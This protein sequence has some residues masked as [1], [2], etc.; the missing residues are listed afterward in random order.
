MDYVRLARPDHWFKN[1]FMVPGMVF[2]YMYFS[3]E[4]TLNLAQNVVIG[5]IATCLIA[6]ANYVINEWLD[7]EFDRH[8]PVKKFRPSV[9][10]NLK[11]N[12]I[13]IEYVGLA[14]VGLGLGYTISNAFFLVLL[15]LLIMGFLY[16]V[17]PFRTKDRAYIDV[18]SESVNNPIRF[19]LGWLIFAPMVMP[20]SSILVAYWMGGAFLMAS[21]RFAE[22]RFI[23][24]KS[25][26]SLYRKSFG[27][28][29]ETS[30]LVSAFYYAVACTFFLG[31]F[32]IKHRIELLLTFPFLALMFSWYLRIAHRQDSTAQR[33][34]QLYHN[35][36]FMIFIGLL[37]ALF[38]GLLFVDIPRLDYFLQNN[39]M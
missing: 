1:V 10:K 3:P 31:I 21:K 12:I 7:A 4:I 19:V 30:L 17:K 20:P 16:N 6:S 23:N 22:Y 34:E 29:S 38:L 13:Y 24:D 37:T 18:L 14:I 28:Y 27:Q 33:P 9:T 35:W 2:A 11:S 36:K 8:H 25:V 32:L 5:V 26:A 15:L 39:F